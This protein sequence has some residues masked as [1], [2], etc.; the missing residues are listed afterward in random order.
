MFRRVQSQVDG[1]KRQFL[2]DRV[3]ESLQ[4]PQDTSSTESESIEWGRATKAM[5]RV[6]G[7][8]DACRLK[9][10]LCDGYVDTDA[11]LREAKASPCPRRD[12]FSSPGAASNFAAS[13][14]YDRKRGR[15]H[16]QGS[17]GCTSPGALQ[18]RS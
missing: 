4:E 13:S 9:P 12:Q 6:K 3:G 16:D 18:N 14:E 1:V 2:H 8:L 5:L 15:H 17:L 10:V 11:L 7:V